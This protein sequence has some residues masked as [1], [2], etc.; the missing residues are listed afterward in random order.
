MA[1]DLNSPPI[2]RIA[3]ALERI[4]NALETQMGAYAESEMQ[5]LVDALQPPNAEPDLDMA[6]TPDWYRDGRGHYR[7]RVSDRPLEPD[8]IAAITYSPRRDAARRSR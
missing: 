6:N 3:V 4:A 7:E 1:I 8:E 2:T 5:G